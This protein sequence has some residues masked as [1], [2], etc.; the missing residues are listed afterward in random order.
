[1]SMANIEGAKD[2]ADIEGE[3]SVEK[4]LKTYADLR[5]VTPPQHEFL[6]NAAPALPQHAFVEDA[7]KFAASLV[8]TAENLVREA[9]ENL[10]R[11]KKETEEFLSDV[12]T[13]SAHFGSLHA[14]MNGSR[15]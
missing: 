10:A 5:N 7:K 8:K 9:E 4:A 12:E 15:E 11:T 3:K 2:M 14:R 13:K 6:R 1:M